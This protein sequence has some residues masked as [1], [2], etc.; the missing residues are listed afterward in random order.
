VFQL[1]SPR[2]NDGPTASRAGKVRE[3]TV[4]VH[5]PTIPHWR[6]TRALHAALGDAH[7]LPDKSVSARARV[8]RTPVVLYAT[9]ARVN[10]GGHSCTARR[11]HC[12]AR[13]HHCTSSGRLARSDGRAAPT[14][15]ASAR[16]SASVNRATSSLH[17][18]TAL[19]HLAITQLVQKLTSLDCG[20]ARTPVEF[21]HLRAHSIEGQGRSAAGDGHSVQQRS[22]LL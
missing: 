20:R 8:H 7:R 19:L 11:H 22:P 16:Y 3:L 2:A 14:A 18:A 21:L 17:R 10:A 15:A 1:G 5:R 12:S 6:L 9:T 4:E 13:R